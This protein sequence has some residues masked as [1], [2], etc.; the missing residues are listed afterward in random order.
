[1]SKDE[2]ILAKAIIELANR[3]DEEE[4]FKMSKTEV[5]ALTKCF[6]NEFIDTNHHPLASEVMMRM[7]E[8]VKD[9]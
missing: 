9:K 1:M 4:Q 6:S 2:G 3:L 7:I 5:Q 8:F